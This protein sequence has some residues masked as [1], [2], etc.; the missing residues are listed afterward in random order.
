MDPDGVLPETDPTL[1][2][3][4]DI[5]LKPDLDLQPCFECPSDHRLDNEKSLAK[6]EFKTALLRV[7]E[8]KE[9]LD[10]LHRITEEEMKRRSRGVFMVQGGGVKRDVPSEFDE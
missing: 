5:F 4:S 9:E 1:E 3:Q 10:Q 7:K 2:K 8:T 6:M